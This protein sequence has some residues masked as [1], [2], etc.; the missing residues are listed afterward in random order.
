MRKITQIALTGLFVL[1]ISNQHLTSF[2][3]ANADDGI[4][5][6][7]PS[8][9]TML[10]YDGKI[11]SRGLNWLTDTT[12]TVS[13]FQLIKKEPGL[14]SSGIDW[15]N[16]VSIDGTY[17]D[18][19]TGHRAWKAHVTDLE[20]KASYY[21][22]ITANATSTSI[23]EFEVSDGDDSFEFLHYTDP[24]G[25]SYNDYAYLARTIDIA[26]DKIGAPD[27]L[28]CTGD[29]SQTYKNPATNI[30]EW[31]YN[32]NAIADQLTTT[33][34]TPVSGNHD[35]AEHMFYNHF[36]AE[37]PDESATLNGFY[38]SYDV[39]DIH[40]AVVNTND[41][42]TTSAPLAQAQIDWL[43][44]DLAT[45]NA[46]WKILALHKG[47]YTTG[48]H[49]KESD[50]ELL[51]NQL[52][53]IISEYDVDLV[54]QGHDH[55]YA[56]TEPYLWD[57]DGKTP[58][59]QYEKVAFVQDNFSYEYAVNPGTY[60][61]IPNT[62]AAHEANLSPNADNSELMDYYHLA[63][64]N[65]NGLYLN[66][67]PYL[68]MFGYL[69]FQEDRMLYKAYE[70]LTN[71]EVVLYDYF[72]VKKYTAKQAEKQIQSLPNAYSSGIKYQ[73][74]ATMSYFEHLSQNEL[75]K[76]SDE[77]V[78]KIQ[79]FANY[80]NVDA[81]RTA[82]EVV[83][84]IGEL[85]PVRLNAAYL[86]HLDNI[87]IKYNALTNIA[88]TFVEN[89][90]KYTQCRIEYNDRQSAADVDALITSLTSNSSSHEIQ[91][92]RLAYDALTMN[93]KIYVQCYF[94]LLQLEQPQDFLH[95][96]Y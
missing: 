13:A 94:H 77:A 68:P 65:I 60:Y 45:T 69:S 43:E 81:Y 62:V 73:L 41:E 21:Y 38:Y 66:Q 57:S 14:V 26:Y 6:G 22:R 82:R 11:N 83:Q 95:S 51:R 23:F 15:N 74:A 75:D 48:R 4:V 67:Q 32:L 2:T 40:V 25:Y 47:L 53:P 84:L 72:G 8:R 17:N 7:I 87:L 31:G 27:S 28:I 92:V 55:V 35:Q 42:L 19:Y 29:F 18:F 54:L 24:Q 96:Q 33:P 56:R 78:D 34:L 61:V 59:T 50:I 46:T 64:S 10:Y 89:Y 85:E 63:T 39:S 5:S 76:I 71:D 9:I 3:K 20:Y 93:Q 37:L 12:V 30:K 79:S 90:S 86:N 1:I 80:T 16:A 49:Y 70:V 58:S 52:Y 91:Q 88:K 36:N 44:N